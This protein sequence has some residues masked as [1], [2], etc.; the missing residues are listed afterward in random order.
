MEASELDDRLK[1]EGS[2]EYR[3]IP[4]EKNELADGYCN[5]TLDRM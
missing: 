2:V 3:W 5:D 4:R 1:E